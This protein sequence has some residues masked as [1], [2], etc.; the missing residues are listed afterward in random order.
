MKE[1]AVCSGNRKFN[2]GSDIA[3]MCG[4]VIFSCHEF[5]LLC[6]K[7]CCAILSALLQFA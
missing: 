1:H 7:F 3:G 2:Y 5:L 4:S 6:R